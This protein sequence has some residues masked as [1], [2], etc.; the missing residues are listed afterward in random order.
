MFE[1]VAD[2]VG[3]LAAVMADGELDVVRVKNHL[4]RGADASDRAGFR[5]VRGPSEGGSSL[6]RPRGARPG[7]A[8]S[9][10]AAAG[11]AR[12]AGVE[13]DLSAARAMALSVRA[14]GGAVSGFIPPSPHPGT[15]CCQDRDP[16][17]L[18]VDGR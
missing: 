8:V 7:G 3:C 13:S 9:G 17:R 14:P 18:G 16:A 10:F 12:A 5:S 2:L 6:L 4:R 15:S 11:Q 1:R